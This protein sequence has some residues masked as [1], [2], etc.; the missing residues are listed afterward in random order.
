MQLRLSSFPYASELRAAGASVLAAASVLGLSSCS[1]HTPPAHLGV[2]HLRAEVIERLESDPTYFTQGLEVAPDGTVWVGTGLYGE[3]TILQRNPATGEVIHSH[4]LPADIFGEGITHYDNSLWQLSWKAGKAFKY[5]AATLRPTGEATYPGEGWGLCAM[6]N[7]LVL[8]D[9]TST[10]RIL[11]P[12]TFA[13]KSRVDVT[14]EGRAVDK[15]NELECV[16]GAVYANV[17]YSTDILRIDPSDGK[18]TAVID[19]SASTG[20][21]NTGEENPDAVL[22]GIAHIPGTEEFYLTGKLW[23]DLYRVRFVEVE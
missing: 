15:L 23:S 18:V 13:E 12:E 2:E 20:V 8:S 14:L 5:D 11:D 4:D 22:N 7:H 1:A 19:A 3:S 10:L 17:W 21:K 6:D 9:G 16:D